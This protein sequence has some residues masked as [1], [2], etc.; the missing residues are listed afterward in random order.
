MNR[1]K[2]GLI[3]FHNSYNCGSM[4]Q[5]Y[6]LHTILNNYGVDNEIIDFSNEGQKNVYSVFARGISIKNLIKNSIIAFKRKK[7]KI[8]YDSYEQFKNENFKLSPK[9]YNKCEELSDDRYDIV[10]TGSD[11]VWNITIE[12]GDD[13]YFLPW[14]KNAKKV[15]Y[16]P[17]FGAKNILENSNDP[18]KYKKFL[19]SFEAISTRED[20]GK[21]WIKD[22]TNI[23]AEVLLDPTLLLNSED[24]NVIIDKSIETPQ[25][26]IFYYSPGYNRRINKLVS[27]I[28]K[29]YN[30]PVIAFNSKNY[31]VKGMAFSSFKLPDI[32]NP[33]VYLNLIKNATLVITTSFHGTIFSSIF[34][35]N[36]WTIKN[37]GMFGTDDRVL[38]L[39]K[40]LNL[41]DRLISMEFDE[42][43]DYL[44]NKNYEEYNKQLKK[45]KKVSFDYI[46]KNI[47]NEMV[48]Y[49]ERK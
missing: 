4:L 9:T 19:L 14:V 33:A 18:D 30:L 7:I 39:V 2:V 21:K 31:Y 46:E 20:N 27:K 43:F 17:S 32:E 1:N 29:K 25:K 37:G 23:D 49:E 35:R 40:N 8:N 42:E 11:Q 13:A 12:D 47:V 26:Y 22:L 16:A 5:T 34:N 36:F 45:L 48:K 44:K 24:Y 3:T 15:A 10:V 41:E 38:T 6:A 28:S